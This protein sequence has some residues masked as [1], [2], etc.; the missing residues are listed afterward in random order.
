[1]LSRTANNAVLLYVSRGFSILNVLNCD[2]RLRLDVKNEKDP[3]SI[4]TPYIVHLQCNFDKTQYERRESMLAE[5]RTIALDVAARKGPLKLQ[6][7]DLERMYE[8]VRIA[9]VA[10]YPK[11]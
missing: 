7:G 9:F 2:M 3:I 11:R 6:E 4:E 8:T 10:L 1:M 5:L